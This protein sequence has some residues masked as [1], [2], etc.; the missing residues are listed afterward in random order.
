[1][2]AIPRGSRV[3]KLYRPGDAGRFS[4][5][6]AFL[7]KEWMT[8][9][10]MMSEA[11]CRHEASRS[12]LDQLCL[13]QSLIHRAGSDQFFVPALSDDLPIMHYDDHVGRDDGAEPVSDHERRPASHDGLDRLVDLAFAF[14]VDLA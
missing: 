1:M 6:G 10:S 7:P 3:G 11:H 13:V 4:R 8:S 5:A 12:G 9:V 14:G 2:P